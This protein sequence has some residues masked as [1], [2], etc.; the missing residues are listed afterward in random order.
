MSGS[1]LRGS[2]AKAFCLVVICTAIVGIAACGQSHPSELI[3][4]DHSASPTSAYPLAVDL[5]R[6]GKYPSETKSGAGYFY[7]DVLEYRVWFYPKG[8]GDDQYKAF[9]QYEQAL[10]FSKATPDA[11]EPLVLVRQRQWIDEPDPGHYVP[12]SGERITEWQVR[13]LSGSKRTADSIAE[14]MK[15][16]RPVRN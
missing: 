15:H 8:G 13:W 14:F 4:A 6:V 11:E 7:D 12:E 1:P 10:A 9:A 2:V 3:G 16:P 5:N